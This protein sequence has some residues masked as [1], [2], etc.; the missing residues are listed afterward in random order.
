MEHLQT[1]SRGR[2]NFHMGKLY[3]LS[4]EKEMLEKFK[5]IHLTGIIVKNLKVKSINPNFFEPYI[6]GL[7][8]L[9]KQQDVTENEEVKKWRNIYKEMGLKPSKY[10]CSF[11]SILRRY[12]KGFNFLGINNVVDSY[13]SV[14]LL[15]QKCIGGYDLDKIQNKITL[16]FAKEGETCLPIG[17]SEPISLSKN[18]V[19]Y[20]DEEKVLCSYWNYR[21]S[22]YTK[23]TENTKNS[24]FFIDEIDATPKKGKNAIK[25][26]ANLLKDTCDA[27]IIYQFELSNEY[28]T[29]YFEV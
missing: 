24:I 4:I 9:Y 19:V 12:L 23:I 27:Q 2:T 29:N 15:H 3:T 14:S 7:N 16:R 10:H 28:P 6:S 21:D 26:L 20:A 25:D 22:E 8:E 11:E 18:S 1:K 13:N 5:D 17:A